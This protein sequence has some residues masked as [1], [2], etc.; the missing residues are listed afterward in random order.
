MVP[1]KFQ[2]LKILQLIDSLH[3][4]GAERMC[5]NISNV[6]H[7]SGHDVTLCASRE[8]GTL[9]KFITPGVR[10][11]LLKKKSP[12]DL[13][14]FRSLIRIIR[15][16][17]IS[18]VHAHSSSLFWAVA[19]KIFLRNLKVIWHDHLGIRIYDRKNFF[20]KLIS[21][22]IDGIISVNQELVEWSRQNMKVPSERIVMIN[23]FPLLNVVSKQAD[24]A[25]FT[26]VCLA[27]LRPQKDHPTLIRAVA[28]LKEMNLPKS[29][30]VILAGSADNQEYSDMIRTLIKELKLEDIIEMHGSVED[31]A[32]L[33]ASA[34]CGVLTSVSEGLPVAL[35]EYGMAALPVVVTDVGQCSEVV[36]K[37]VYGRV[38]LPKNPGE[39]ANAL[40]WIIENQFMAKEIGEKF[41]EHVNMEYGP[42]KFMKEYAVLLNRLSTE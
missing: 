39:V 26:I 37:G 12:V 4:G 21:T 7:E 33:L 20:Y 40:Q 30:K 15:D 6:L 23:N 27:N 10:Y 38:V 22:K 5:V 16:N 2:A 29:L 42:D 19:A 28:E 32:S 25:V 14:A 36:S 11:C 35:L 24:P 31:T 9:E 34:E 1:E 3:S 17:E 13:A 18:V 41:R 8:G